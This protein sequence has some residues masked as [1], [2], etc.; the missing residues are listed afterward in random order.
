MS[1]KN[2]IHPRLTRILAAALLLVTV[3]P[4]AAG[5]SSEGPGGG[6]AEGI[7]T[8]AN[9]SDPSV[10]GFLSVAPDDYGEWAS[11]TFGGGG[12]IFNPAGAFAPLEATFTSALFLSVPSRTQRIVLTDNPNQL[13]LGNDASLAIAVSSPL[14]ASDTDGDGVDD[15]LVSSF[16]A[17][18]TNTALSFDLTQAVS[19]PAAGVALMQQDYVITN[20]SGMS[21]DIV[22][23]RVYDGDL[24]WDGDFS[25]D[26]VGT[27]YNMAGGDVYVFEQEAAAPTP[28]SITISSPQAISYFGGKHGVQPAGGPP[29]YDFGTDTE[30]FD[31]FGI[32]A[33]WVNH[34]AGVGYDLDGVSGTAPAGSTAPEDGFTG[35]G[36]SFT[37]APAESTTI[38]VSHTYGQDFP[39]QPVPTI[40][41]P[42]LGWTGL[43]ALAAVLALAG[44]LLV[45]RRLYPTS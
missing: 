14:A 40:E 18:G 4:V 26:Q 22:L 39:G 43:A 34:I 17:T 41:I 36:F 23:A 9:G 15:T 21:V 5:A 37:L 35:I 3:G 29:P 6:V 25:N 8:I 19:S 13:A 20:D 1:A 31:A 32:P 16:T 10:D 38:S 28:T 30:V 33:S 7:L 12:D 11:V 2:V 24:L 42:T 27:G 44:G 45:R